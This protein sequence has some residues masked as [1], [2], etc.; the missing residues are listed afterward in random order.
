MSVPDH[1][2]IIMDGNGRWASRRGMPRAAGHRSGAQAVRAIVES[3]REQSVKTLTLFAFS[4]ENWQRP[5]TEVRVLLDLFRRTIRR[6]IDS[7]NESGVRL[8]FIGERAHF[9]EALRH[10]MAQAEMRTHDNTALN[11]VIAIDYGGRWDLV[12]AARRLACAC[13]DNQ[14]DPDEIDEHSLGARLAL[15][16]FPAPDLFIRTGGERR[17][18]NF[19][20]WD[21][22][23]SEL[24]FSDELWPD[25]DSNSLA[26]A[27]EWFGQRQRRFGRL[28]QAAATGL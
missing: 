24:Y 8:S 9:S 26:C 2:A 23:Y 10:E 14:L 22:A 21:L 28:P 3:A 19:L 25:F 27:I 7:M 5:K 18:S 17:V 15:A 4:S 20:L 16:E 11:L 1:V 6:E 12:Q 13:R